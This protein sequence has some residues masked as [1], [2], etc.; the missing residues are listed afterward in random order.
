M[1]T[2][3]LIPVEFGASLDSGLS[4]KKMLKLF[5]RLELRSHPMRLLSTAGP[6]LGGVFWVLIFREDFRIGTTRPIGAQHPAIRVLKPAQTFFELGLFL[7][8]PAS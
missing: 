3:L 8:Y 4:Y 1:A 7:R 5:A 2:K 6:F